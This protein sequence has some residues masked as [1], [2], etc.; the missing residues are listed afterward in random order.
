MPVLFPVA[1]VTNYHKLSSQNNV[2]LL[3]YHSGGPKCRL[4]LSGWTSHVSGTVLLSW[5]PRGGSA[6]CL[7]W[8]LEAA[9]AVA[10][11]FH[12]ESLWRLWGVFLKLHHPTLVR[13][14][15][16]P[17]FKDACDDFGPTW[18][19]QNNARRLV[20]RLNPSCYLNSPSPWKEFTVPGIRT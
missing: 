13:F 20:S 6:P 4:S 10:P 1:S 19:F 11:R 14:P 2:D 5:G 9:L 17:A 18:A 8:L 12:L 3:I 16:S 15:S 7:L